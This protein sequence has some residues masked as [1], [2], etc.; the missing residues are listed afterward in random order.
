MIAHPVGGIGLAEKRQVRALDG[1]FRG[2]VENHVGS[3]A[4]GYL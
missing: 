1:G 2:K 3:E 4:W